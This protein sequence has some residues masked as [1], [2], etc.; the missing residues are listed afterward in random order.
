ML[1]DK[2]KDAL[3]ET[4]AS[5]ARLP[6]VVG[7]H[8]DVCAHCR[9]ALIAQQALAT[10]MDV[11]LRSRVSVA[12]PANFNHRLRAA[13]E[14]QFSARNTSYSAVFAFGSIAAV[15]AV[16]IAMLCVYVWSQAGISKP[17]TTTLERT[18]QLDPNLEVA[19]GNS[20]EHQASNPE[21]LRPQWETLIIPH[22]RRPLASVAEN[23]EVLVPEGQ[24]ELVVKYMQQLASRSPTA[25]IRVDLHSEPSMKQVEVA[26][27]EIAQLVVRPLPDLS[28]K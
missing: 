11:E 5:G 1:C 19:L 14:P 17:P 16:M 6:R 13:L 10:A 7:E 15:A 28:S 9:E 12:V 3:M 20:N 8:V 24:E 2:Y 27:V 18:N 23:V 4:A 26:P 22:R 25:T 21:A